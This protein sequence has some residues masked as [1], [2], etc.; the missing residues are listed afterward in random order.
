M[1][2][3]FSIYSHP[4]VREACRVIADGYDRPINHAAEVMARENVQISEQ[5]CIDLLPEYWLCDMFDWL[6]DVHDWDLDNPV[7]AK[8]ETDDWKIKPIGQG[9]RIYVSVYNR[10]HGQTDIDGLITVNGNLTMLEAKGGKYFYYK[11]DLRNKVDLLE[12]VMG[13]TPSYV[14]GVPGDNQMSCCEGK[15]N[16]F[17]EDRGGLMLTFPATSDEILQKATELYKEMTGR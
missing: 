8:R 6:R 14:L 4:D 10:E 16:V 17:V 1:G 9:N 2:D 15:R 11:W 3:P 12:T 5:L 13:E 7:K